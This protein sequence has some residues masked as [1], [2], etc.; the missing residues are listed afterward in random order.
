MGSGEY[1]V[2]YPFNGTITGI[3]SND[4]STFDGGILDD[5]GGGGKFKASR[6][7]LIE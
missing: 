7:E 2:D 1:G 6:L 5:E 3:I 4:L